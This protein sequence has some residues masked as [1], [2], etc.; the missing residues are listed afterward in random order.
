MNFLQHVR[1]RLPSPQKIPLYQDLSK[2]AEKMSPRLAFFRRRIRLRE[3]SRISIPLGLVLLFPCLLVIIILLLV[4]RHT[5]SP[6][7]IL[8]PAGAPPAIRYLCHTPALSPCTNAMFAEGLAK[9]TTRSL[10]LAV[11]TRPSRPTNR[12]QTPPLSSSPVTR[13]SKVCYSP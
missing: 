11:K 5:D 1:K 13:S 6:G 9:S 10:S 7:R 3:N 8:M 12:A 4:V 2:S